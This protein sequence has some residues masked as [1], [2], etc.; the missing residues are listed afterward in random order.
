MLARRNLLHDRVRFVVTLTGIVFSVVLSAIQLGLFVGFNRA[1][2]DLIARSQADIWIRSAGVNNLE[3]AVPFSEQKLHRIRSLPGVARAEKYI[4]Q[5]GNWTTPA[6]AEEGCLVIG[7]TPDAEMGLPWNLVDGDRRLLDE[8]DGVI[9]DE[10]YRSKLGVTAVGDV[11]EIRGHRARVVGFTRGIRTFTTAPPVFTSFKRAQDFIG[12][13][14]DQAL[15]ILVRAEP[16]ADVSELARRI[17]ADV[18]DVDAM[19]TDDWR[20]AQEDYWMLGTG[21]GVSVLIAAGLGLLVGVVIVAQTIY[22]ATVDHIREFGT[23]KAMGATN[24]Y[25]YG[26]I[27]Q[28]AVIN[29]VIGYAIAI[30]IA[31][32]VSRGSLAGT[33]AI[34]LPWQLA[35]GLFVLTVAMCVAASVVSIHKVTRLDPAMVFKG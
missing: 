17:N 6:G 27:V 31:G 26:V 4:V 9:V 11:R 22:S 28:Q 20:R 18:A 7:V 32:V 10:L 3:S 15:Y 1:T 24:R 8:P 30:V 5:F 16:G 2:S 14:E 35:A 12:L 25:L 13:P 21:A 33:T 23:L 29:A 34:M 19:P